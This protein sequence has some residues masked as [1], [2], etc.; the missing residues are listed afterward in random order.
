L[1]VDKVLIPT[2][3]LLGTIY[4]I[5]KSTIS[6][7]KLKKIMMKRCIGFLLLMNGFAPL[8]LSSAFKHLEAGLANIA[9]AE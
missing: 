8:V 4:Y 2:P 3:P 9:R 7:I 1:Y 6:Q 5:Q